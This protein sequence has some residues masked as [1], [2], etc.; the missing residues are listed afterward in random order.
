MFDVVAATVDVKLRAPRHGDGDN[1]TAL[2]LDPPT[3]E[4]WSGLLAIGE[5]LFDAAGVVATVVP[6]VTSTLLASMAGRR[7]TAACPDASSEP[8][9]RCRPDR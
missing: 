5:A 9:R 2:V 3:T 7:H 6:T 8:L 1:G 4:R